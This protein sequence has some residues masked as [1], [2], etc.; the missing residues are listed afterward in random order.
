MSQDQKAVALMAAIHATG[1]RLLKVKRP[2]P[3]TAGGTPLMNITIAVHPTSTMTLAKEIELVKGAL[4]YADHVTLCSPAYELLTC[5]AALAQS[6]TDTQMQ[7]LSDVLPIIA[8]DQALLAQTLKRLMGRGHKRTAAELL[9]LGQL[10][11]Q[12]PAQWK[13]M[14]DFINRLY[15]DAGGGELQQPIQ[16]GLLDLDFLELRN[17][18][19]DEVVQ[20]FMKRLHEYLNDAR[21]YPMFDDRA[22]NLARLALDAGAFTA[23]ATSLNRADEAGLG[24]GL[25]DHLPSFPDANIEAVL[26]TRQEV[27]EHVG[28][29]RRAVSKMREGIGSS[30]LDADFAQEVERVFLAEVRAAVEDI[31]AAMDASSLGRRLVAAGNKQVGVAALSLG[32]FQITDWPLLVKVGVTGVAATVATA[33]GWQSASEGKRQAEGNDLFFLYRTERELDERS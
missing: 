32:M 20:G 25:I 26:E 31:Q 19:T 1:R 29:F 18:S 2:P 21:A 28:R 14:A 7:F 8:P 24:T 16:R 15:L 12:L 22:G 13:P 6:D 5:S 3:A 17:T 4:L 23:S 10:K 30:A 11:K 33:A 27:E 9:A